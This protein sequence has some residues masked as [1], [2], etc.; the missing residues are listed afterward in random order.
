MTSR[1]I[2]PPSF[3]EYPAVSSEEDYAD[4]RMASAPPYQQLQN[5]PFDI[6]LDDGDPY[7]LETG[8]HASRGGVQLADPPAIPADH[9]AV[10]VPEE[11]PTY[12]ETGHVY[13]GPTQLNST[14][15]LGDPFGHQDEKAAYSYYA[16]P[17]EDYLED[18]FSQDGFYDEKGEGIQ[19]Q[20]SRT[21]SNFSQ[22]GSN[23]H[24]GPA[25]MHPLA[26]RRNE[27]KTVE[28]T[29]GNLVSLVCSL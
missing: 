7:A 15:D 28:L 19:G 13:S 20:H 17:A 2:P 29:N 1:R 10:E 27:K 6:N 11:E 23:P 5:S 16:T 14:N 22:D 26:R 21:A 24:Y 8:F 12:E 18:D 25:P 4:T 3:L 9:L